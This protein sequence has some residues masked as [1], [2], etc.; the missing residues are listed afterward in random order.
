M[1]MTAR[2]FDCVPSC[3]LICLLEMLE[4]VL[5]HIY[6]SN[7]ISYALIADQCCAIRLLTS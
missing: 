3:V 4:C 6:C 1:T 2:G 5:R 7:A